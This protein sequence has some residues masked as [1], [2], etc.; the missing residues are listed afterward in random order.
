MLKWER[1]VAWRRNTVLTSQQ[2]VL[3]NRIASTAG[4]A[5]HNNGQAVPP[6]TSEMPEHAEMLDHK[7]R[8]GTTSL[9]TIAYSSVV[10]RELA[11]LNVRNRKS[12]DVLRE[13]VDSKASRI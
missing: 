3:Y 7:Y 2:L 12:D 13:A 4:E 10:D 5:S 1:S 6:E 8:C 9:R 11:T